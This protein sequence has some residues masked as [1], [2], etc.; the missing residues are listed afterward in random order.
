MVVLGIPSDEAMLSSTIPDET[1][2][3]EC[4]SVVSDRVW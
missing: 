3:S 2:N 1:V 4:M